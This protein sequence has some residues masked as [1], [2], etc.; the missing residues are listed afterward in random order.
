[1]LDHDEQI[2][3]S[4]FADLNNLNNLNNLNKEKVLQPKNSD[5]LS[6]LDLAK[7]LIDDL[8]IELNDEDKT[9]I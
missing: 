3:I 2:P 9:I 7:N 8:L 5:F 4:Y 1:M 6:K